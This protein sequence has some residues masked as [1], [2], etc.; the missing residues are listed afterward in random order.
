M[1]EKLI[2]LGEMTREHCSQ[3]LK[4]YHKDHCRKLIEYGN[5][6][7]AHLG[8]HDCRW[9]L[10]LIA[11]GHDLFKKYSLD[12][13][14][15]E[16]EGIKIPYDT[17]KYIDENKDVL[18]KFGLSMIDSENF[19]KHPTAAGIF[20]YK[21][22]GIEDPALIYPVF[23]HSC[24]VVSVYRELDER[25]R[26]LVDVVMLA[27]KLSANSLTRD[28]K[29]WHKKVNMDLCLYGETGREFN[30]TNAL[31]TAKILGQAGSKDVISVESV[32]YYYYRA[33]EQNPALDKYSRLLGG[34]KPWKLKKVETLPESIENEPSEIQEQSP[35][36]DTNTVAP[37][38][39][40]I[41]ESSIKKYLRK[42]IKFQERIFGLDRE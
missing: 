18:E 2:A 34:K 15:L 11:Y 35:T 31:L 26:T 42:F 41:K 16:L 5:D 33:C 7:F 6:I 37:E 4:Q 27:D 22:L 8:I 10:E 9:E 29:K 40:E 21:E 38:E 39:K 17:K 30:Y 1:R 28:F 3:E 14:E 36:L 23:F 12:R 32:R 20:L 13:G 19:S 25:T 24:P